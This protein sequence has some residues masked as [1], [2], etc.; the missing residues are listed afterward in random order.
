MTGGTWEGFPEV[1]PGVVL[2]EDLA[3]AGIPYLVPGPDGPLFFD[4]HA[5][6]HW[7]C[8]AMANLPG[9]SPKTLMEVC[10]HSDPRL[11]LN[12]Y[13][14]ARQEDVRAA[15]QQVPVIGAAPNQRAAP[16]G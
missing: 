7:Y 3:E 4:F 12:V 13:A 6:R 15:A 9:I 10:R 11:T 14:K 2:Q 8:T 1:R 16:R 5:L